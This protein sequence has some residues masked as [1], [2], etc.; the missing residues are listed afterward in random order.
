MP[1]SMRLSLLTMCVELRCTIVTS[2]SFSHNAPQMSNALLLLPMT[3]ALLPRYASGPGCREEWWTSP[4]K[5]SMPSTS[6]IL[7]LPDIPVAKTSWVGRSV[8]GC[9][10][11][12]TSTVHSPAS[13]DHVADFA[14]VL[15]QYGIS[16]TLTYDSSQS[17]ILS[18]GAKTG[19]FSGNF[20]YGRWSYQTGS[21]RHSDL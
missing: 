17:P 3:T 2:A 9:P 1:Y 11:R 19:Q 13:S 16:M 15:D 18:L 21:W 5:M 12:S 7:G 6:G 20:R 10:S 14:S 8:C 4:R